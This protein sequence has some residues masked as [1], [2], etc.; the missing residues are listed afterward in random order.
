MAK[1]K[2]KKAPVVRLEMRWGGLFSFALV[3]FCLMLWM[4]LLGIWAGQTVL[5]RP[6][7]LASTTLGRD[8]AGGQDPQQKAVDV[9]PAK[10]S[11][12]FYAIQVGA[13]KDVARAK[14]AV[15]EWQ[16]KKYEAFYILP[17]Q[18]SRFHRVYIGH[19]LDSATAR[20]KADAL[21]DVLKSK[22]F[23]SRIAGDE[24]LFFGKIL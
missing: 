6:V 20:K 15:A 3:A 11:T 9:V 10:R 1:R 24:K 16:A 2:K 21:E 5:R 13:F 14:K 19:F 4:F 7:T 8:D 18:G 17:R 12:S 23:I 22:V